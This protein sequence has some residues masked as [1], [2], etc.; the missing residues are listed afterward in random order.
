MPCREALTVVCCPAA[1]DRKR[2]G[3]DGAAVVSTPV[4]KIE[5]RQCVSILGEGRGPL[6]I[7]SYTLNP[8]LFAPGA[9]P[10]GLGPPKSKDRRA[11]PRRGRMTE[12]RARRDSRRLRGLRSRPR[13]RHPRVSALA[14]CWNP[15]C[16]DAEGYRR[17]F[18]TMRPK[19]QCHRDSDGWVINPDVP[20]YCSTPCRMRAAHLRDGVPLDALAPGVCEECSGELE[21]RPRR[22]GRRAVRYRAG[23]P[24]RFCGDLCRKAAYRRAHPMPFLPLP[25]TTCRRCGAPIPRSEHAGRPRTTC[26]DCRAKAPAP[27]TLTA[28]VHD[29]APV[30][31]DPVDVGTAAVPDPDEA[32]LAERR[33]RRD[34]PDYAAWVRRQEARRA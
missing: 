23:R 19:F 16:R 4:Q 34:D 5:Y 26:D 20:A 17:V 3:G 25:P 22:R 6:G 30:E 29:G 8:L 18:T 27:K 32:A 1:R 12:A 21:P 31:A 15:D 2:V 11:P 7:P 9:V 10:S 28:V 14:S 24:A 33:K 13:P